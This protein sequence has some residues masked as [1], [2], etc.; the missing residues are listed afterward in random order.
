MALQFSDL[1]LGQHRLYS[2]IVDGLIEDWQMDDAYELAAKM[3]SEEL[4]VRCIERDGPQAA[5]DRLDNLLLLKR[6]R[7]AVL[8]EEGDV[9]A[10]FFDVLKRVSASYRLVFEQ[11]S[12]AY[13]LRDTANHV[14]SRQMGG[15]GILTE[16]LVRMLECCREFISPETLKRPYFG[17]MIISAL[18]SEDYSTY[19]ADNLKVLSFLLPHMGY[20]KSLWDGKLN[21]IAKN[22]PELHELVGRYRSKDRKTY[23]DYFLAGLARDGSTHIQDELKERAGEFYDFVNGLPDDQFNQAMTDDCLLVLLEA[24]WL[25]SGQYQHLA[26]DL[27]YQQGHEQFVRRLVSCPLMADRIKEIPLQSRSSMPTAGLMFTHVFAKRCGVELELSHS[28][29]SMVEVENVTDLLL[30]DKQK[31]LFDSV[32]DKLYEVQRRVLRRQL[33]SAEIAD[34]PYLA[35]CGP[36]VK[37]ASDTQEL[38]A[39]A[40]QFSIEWGYRDLHGLKDNLQPSQLKALPLSYRL[41]QKAVLSSINRK[42][43]QGLALSATKEMA[44]GLAKH[45]DAYHA[46]AVYLGLIGSENLH[47]LSDRDQTRL[48]T[49]MMDI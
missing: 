8:E 49:S 31:G 12:M 37:L 4:L 27:A 20:D 18:D 46:G 25:S 35:T 3:L 48:M 33:M 29:G 28:M 10:I 5:R 9:P 1:D 40:L 19:N 47:E 2:A 32:K 30:E 15:I 22:S 34:W 41:S 39:V 11:D 36:N 23:Q 45:C 26:N 24:R 14:R 21:V 43:C 44:E 16:P 17:G 7:T 6:F 38:A 42:V 13:V